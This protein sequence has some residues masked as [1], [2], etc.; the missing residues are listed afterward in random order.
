[1]RAFA[2]ILETAGD[3]AA[4][5]SVLLHQARRIA[6][7]SQV[8]LIRAGDESSHSAA[9]GPA[10]GER[11]RPHAWSRRPSESVDEIPIRCGAADHG[12]L[13]FLSPERGR[14]ALTE[15][16]RRRLDSVCTLAAC[17]LETRLSQGE[18]A[19]RAGDGPGEDGPGGAPAT[20]CGAQPQAHRRPGHAAPVVRDA[21]FLNAVLPFALGQARR[22]RESVALLCVAIDRLGA[23]RGLLGPEA[24]DHMVREVA[25]TVSSRVR[26]SDIVA[27]LDDD[28]MV[29]LLV[30]ARGSTALRVARMIG[31]VVAEANR[32]ATVLPGMTVSI[33]VADFPAAAGNA[34]SLL[35]AADEA[36]AR[37]QGR[38]P[39][40]IVLADPR[41]P[42][43]QDPD[44][45]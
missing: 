23:I 16:A 39:N 9:E 15:E 37:A 21:T 26:S 40:Q 1:M 32:A 36:L 18:W 35:D 41:S 20:T 7:T 2:A 27:R 17:V 4:W 6:P 34:Y 11:P 28:R 44:G 12:H 24:A 29:V 43:G 42:A 25:A 5:E 14:G 13:R 10:G 45:E 38:G 31:R 33:G 30:R 19:G 3:R 8:E 22:H